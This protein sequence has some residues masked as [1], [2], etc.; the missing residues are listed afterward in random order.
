MKIK[1]DWERR[2]VWVDEKYLSPEMSQ[3]VYNHSPDGHCW[4]YSGSGPSQL[5]LSILLYHF[6]EKIA[7][8][9][10]QCFKQDV[11]AGLPKGDFQIEI[12]LEKW[13]EEKT[14]GEI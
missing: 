2:D 5:A 8:K 1:G 3:N 9:Y 14:K 10:Y 13:L 6:P 4:G 11:I 12:D 7:V